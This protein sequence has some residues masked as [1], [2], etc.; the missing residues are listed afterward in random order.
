M[1]I[2]LSL[3]Q[4]LIGNLA[5]WIFSP[6]AGTVY[7]EWKKVLKKYGNTIPPRY[8]PRTAFTTTMSLMNTALAHWEQKKY[9]SDLESIEVKSPIFIIGHHRSGTTHLWRLLTNDK[10]FVYPTVT[11]TLFPE[12]L[13]TFKNIAHK[14]ASWFSPDERPQDKVKHSA[15][16]P[17]GEEWGL[18]SST[19][20]STHMSR[21]F[22]EFRDHFKYMLSLKD[23]S[24]NQRTKWKKALYKF[25]QK[26]LYRSDP[27][28]TI[29]F[30]A[31]T[32]TAKIQLLLEV[33]P[34]AQFIHI[35]R[36]PYRVYQSTMKMERKSLPYCCYQSKNLQ[37][38]EDYVIWRYKKMY[39]TFLKDKAL[40]PEGNLTQLAYEDLVQNRVAAIEKIY[41]DLG[42]ESFSEIKPGLLEYIESIADY[43]TNNYPSLP[44]AKK[45][46]IADAWG[47]CFDAFGY[48]TK[49]YPLQHE[50]VKNT[51]V[52]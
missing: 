27:D 19:F 4:E 24:S 18:C 23:A 48:A 15:D 44:N 49:L 28:A 33:F 42:L 43:E 25:A 11:E 29:L 17:L 22:P 26:L 40:I 41:H 16:S 47:H 36:N 21:Y 5:R 52:S 51:A 14:L 39:H 37:G 50:E 10:R 30:K 1:A 35:Y 38:L 12:T 8:W 13:L 20:L 31:P 9:R 45:R 32:N 2:T 34:D 46:K 3:R 6:L 7:S